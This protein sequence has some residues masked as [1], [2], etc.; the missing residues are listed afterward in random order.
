MKLSGR[1]TS[2]FYFQPRASMARHR[3]HE[4]TAGRMNLLW[5]HYFR[6]PSLWYVN[7]SFKVGFSLYLQKQT[8]MKM[9]NTYISK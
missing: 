7:G 3:K 2:S 8:W 4:C 5:K 9:R 6:D 1:S